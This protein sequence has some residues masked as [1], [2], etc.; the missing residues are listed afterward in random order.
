MMT[1]SWVV[2]GGD[3]DEL[4]GSKRQKVTHSSVLPSPPPAALMGPIPYPMMATMH[5]NQ[6]IPQQQAGPAPLPP[7][8][9]F[10]FSQVS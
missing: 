9:D 1:P 7:P 2:G 8:S 3:G 6:N 10:M 4:V 5:G